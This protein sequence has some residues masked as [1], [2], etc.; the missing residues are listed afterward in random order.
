MAEVVY[1][2][3]DR[4]FDSI[5]FSR[6]D[7]NIVIQWQTTNSTG[8]TIMGLSRNY[9]KDVETIPGKMIFGWPISHE[10]T[11]APTDIRFS[12][13][14]YILGDENSEHVFDYSFSTLPNTV[15]VKS[16][17]N[18]DVEVTQEID[19][20]S[21]ITRRIKRSG[22]YDPSFPIPA[23]PTIIEHSHAY[24]GSLTQRIVDLDGNGERELISLARITDSGLLDYQWYKY[25][26]IDNAQYS[27]SGI[28]ISSGYTYRQIDPQTTTLEN[29]RTYYQKINNTYVLLTSLPRRMQSG[30]NFYFSLNGNTPVDVY[31]R[32]SHVVAT[33]AGYYK[34]SITAKNL[35]N[36]QT[37]DDNDYVIIPGPLTPIVNL[38]ASLPTNITEDEEMVHAIF[39]GSNISLQINAI[40]GESQYTAESVGDNPNVTLTY[41]WTNMNNNEVVG[42]NPIYTVTAS[43][44]DYFDLTLQ[45]TVQAERN[46][47]TTSVTYKPFRVTQP[48]QKPS[49]YYNGNPLDYQRNDNVISISRIAA[50]R[51]ATLSFSI[52][53]ALPSDHYSYIWV[54]MNPSATTRI[55]ELVVDLD[56]N[57]QELLPNHNPG[58]EGD[59][60]VY[61]LPYNNVDWVNTWT[62]RDDLGTLVPMAAGQE[63]GP[64]LTLNNSLGAGI[65]YCVVINN[66]NGNRAANISP[67]F[68]VY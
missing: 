3:I 12:V 35:V 14:F 24:N 50:G 32:V 66:Y 48:P 65:Y 1:F 41:T 33:E 37:I 59:W 7:M 52:D 16:T 61:N 51:F 2:S 60:D 19:H 63:N 31:E 10:L 45:V 55:Q 22:V 11:D 68:N 13:R 49:I 20:G 38:P 67:F 18:H 42:H 6:H 64:S 28:P 58:G 56:T 36:S 54:Y 27:S 44:D 34:V 23:A 53:E 4:F 5:D 17:L 15:S 57:L 30:N 9:G 29:N 39:Q 47:A 46:L 40:S 26:Y 8:E 62:E 43:Q 25:S 21:V